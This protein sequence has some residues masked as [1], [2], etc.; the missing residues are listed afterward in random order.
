M[1]RHGGSE[2]RV[3]HVFLSVELGERRRDWDRDRA[4][5]WKL[6]GVER[7]TNRDVNPGAAYSNMS[8]SAFKRMNNHQLV[9]AS[10]LSFVDDYGMRVATDVEAAEDQKRR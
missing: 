10:F 4:L 6:Q 5:R 2:T 9:N 1:A 3:I 8:P 7:D